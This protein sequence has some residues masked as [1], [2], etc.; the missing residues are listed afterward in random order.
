MY[1]CDGVDYPEI[2]IDTP[3][4]STKKEATEEMNAGQKVF[5]TVVKRFLNGFIAFF[6]EPMRE[7]GTHFHSAMN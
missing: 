5:K 7:R 3:F 6:E 1:L 4:L 2:L